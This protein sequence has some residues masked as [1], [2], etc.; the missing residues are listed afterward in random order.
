MTIPNDD[1]RPEQPRS[2]G[3]LPPA[4]PGAGYP[5]PPPAPAYGAPG[6]GTGAP[7]TG[8]PGAYPAYAATPA[9]PAGA[10]AA[11]PSQVTIGFWLY[12]AAAVLSVISGIVTVVVVVN[13]RQAALDALTN[14]STTLKGITAQ[15][16]ADASIAVG[17]ILSIIT[18]LFWA[19]T[20]TVFALLM[21][22][23]AGWARIV[24]TV[25]TVLSL[26]N[27]PWG[28]GAGGLQ[29]VAAIVATVLIWLRPAS[30]YFAAVKAS[31]ALRA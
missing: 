9:A 27:I 25:L 14:G 7:E 17:T 19:I 2:D 15:Q 10:P 28:Y 22:R 8:V 13:S 16:A 1:D 23:G 11:P 31:R 20:F 24:L 4:D 3:P 12:I 29:V 6:T 26:V 30:E 18:L 5:P 21:R